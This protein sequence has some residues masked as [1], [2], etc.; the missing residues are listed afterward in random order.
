MAKSVVRRV[1]I[2]MDS[3]LNSSFESYLKSVG[4]KLKKK[5]SFIDFSNDLAESLLDSRADLNWIFSRK[6]SDLKPSSRI[7]I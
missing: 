1:G 5:P 6:N 4:P 7:N 3:F 2:K